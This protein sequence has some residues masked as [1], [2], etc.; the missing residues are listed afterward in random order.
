MNK[1]SRWEDLESLAGLPKVMHLTLYSN[2]AA[3]IPGYRH[4]LVNCI[5]SLLALDD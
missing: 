5:P 2:P 4:Y 1:I 3:A